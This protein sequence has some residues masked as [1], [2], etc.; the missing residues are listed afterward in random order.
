MRRDIRVASG[1]PG[2]DGLLIELSGTIHTGI[3]AVSEWY[4]FRI[5]TG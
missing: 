5:P 1:S 4:N 2:S 3:V